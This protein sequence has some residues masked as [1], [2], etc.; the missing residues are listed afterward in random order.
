MKKLL[1]F[2]LLLHRFQSLH[3]QAA[4]ITTNLVNTD[5]AVNNSIGAGGT[6][7]QLVTP[8][9]LNKYFAKT[10][11]YYLTGSN[12]SSLNRNY[13]FLNAGDNELVFGHNRYFAQANG[14]IRS[15]WTVGFKAELNKKFAEL[16]NNNGASANMGLNLKY[17]RYL[18]GTVFFDGPVTP[19]PQKC[20][21]NHL[22]RIY[23]MDLIRKINDESNQFEAGIADFNLN[24]GNNTCGGQVASTTQSRTDFYNKLLQKYEDLYYEKEVE[25]LENAGAKNAVRVGWWSITGFVPFTPVRYQTIT[26]TT[27][28][29]VE[30]ADYLAELNWSGNFLYDSDVWG[31]VLLSAGIS[32]VANNSVKSE[33]MQTYSINEI[34]PLGIN[35]SVYKKDHNGDIYLGDY[36][37]YLSGVTNFQAIFFPKNANSALFT[38]NWGV[39][40]KFEYEFQGTTDK[41]NLRFGIPFVVKGKDDE[42]PVN[43]EVQFKLN[44]TSRWTNEG[45]NYSI[46]IS[47]GLPFSSILY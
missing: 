31:R 15:V 14:R 10:I 35:D 18:T 20:A 45:K 47:V 17:T 2:F 16:L 19:G 30:K 37:S 6:V 33:K 9:G 32:G 26:T 21:M 34:V 12:S 4:A 11:G 40:A 13:L 1:L 43:F 42:N 46:G 44:D 38:G 25:L 27:M 41:I 22:R 3:S 24:P 23:L 36:S 29:P 39:S 28:L 5:N 8:R 7:P